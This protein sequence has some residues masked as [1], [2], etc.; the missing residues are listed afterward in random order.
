MIAQVGADGA[1]RGNVG[2]VARYLL[3]SIDFLEQRFPCHLAVELAGEP[4]DEPSDL[5]AVF[6]VARE[7]TDAARGRWWTPGVLSQILG[8]C[9]G[10]A[11]DRAASDLKD[12]ELAG[13]IELQELRP[14]LPRPLLEHVRFDIVLGQCQPNG[15]GL[16]AQPKMGEFVH[17]RPMLRVDC[18]NA[19]RRSYCWRLVRQKQ[20]PIRGRGCKSLGGACGPEGDQAAVL[21]ASGRSTGCRVKFMTSIQLL[22][23]CDPSAMIRERK[24][25]TTRTSCR[26]SQQPVGSRPLS[27]GEVLHSLRTVHTGSQ[28]DGALASRPA[29]PDRRA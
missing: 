10:A 14:P 1:H 24:L 19:F 28:G 21:C 4:V 20:G 13:R 17:V 25:A 18:K 12:R 6:R 8:D 5:G 23:G 16:G 15:S 26:R 29:R 3:P 9:I 22:G 11:Q 2:H 27:R 7:Q